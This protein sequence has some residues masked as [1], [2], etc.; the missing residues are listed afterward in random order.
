MKVWARDLPEH[1][2]VKAVGISL[3]QID[4]VASVVH[5]KV[6]A[7]LLECQCRTCTLASEFIF[8]EKTI[9]QMA[10]TLGAVNTRGVGSNDDALRT[11]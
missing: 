9:L 8:A 6:V 5:G 10:Q 2:R 1:Q 11:M 3:E 7:A 4:S